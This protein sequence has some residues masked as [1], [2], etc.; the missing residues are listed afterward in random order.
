MGNDQKVQHGEYEYQIV[1]YRE[2]NGMYKGMVLLTAH[3]GIQYSP[4]VEI[5]TPSVFKTERAA[6]IEASALVCQ[7]IEAGAVATLVP[8]NGK[9]GSWPKESQTIL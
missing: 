4:I 1:S 5:P 8:Q 6:Q 2:V 9:S 7:L 3:A